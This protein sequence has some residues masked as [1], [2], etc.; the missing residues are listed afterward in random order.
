MTV[1]R[2]KLGKLMRWEQQTDPEFQHSI[3]HGA[4]YP[5]HCSQERTEGYFAVGL[6]VPSAVDAD[7]V[8]TDTPFLKNVMSAVPTDGDL[9]LSRQDLRRRVQLPIN[10]YGLAI[11]AVLE[12]AFGLLHQ[13]AI[14]V[15]L[16]LNYGVQSVLIVSMYVVDQNFIDQYGCDCTAG[17][18]WI[19]VFVFVLMI[20]EE[21]SSTLEAL[22]LL[23]G[24]PSGDPLAIHS[25]K[26][27]SGRATPQRTNSLESIASVS[28]DGWCMC[29]GAEAEANN[30]DWCLCSMSLCSD[31]GR[32]YEMQFSGYRLKWMSCRSKC[33]LALFV[34]LP[35][36]VL[37]V[38]LL[39]VGSSYIMLS[40]S[41]ED[42]IT[43]MVSVNFIV[44]ID[45]M[46]LS[47]VF[48]ARAVRALRCTPH[49]TYEPQS[50]V[51]RLWAH[52]RTDLRTFVD[53][54]FLTIITHII[55]R[56]L[57]NSSGCDNSMWGLMP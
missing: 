8:D 23:C 31:E 54:F 22:E 25:V 2:R 7:E 1:G 21:L 6:H 12:P 50:C 53:P 51:M 3:M 29:H 43:S 32:L 26:E 28:E 14:I 56:Y 48:P 9:P 34:V 47:G 44:A 39:L 11:A 55:F 24:I 10:I 13:S 5:H 19:G 15:L 37:E 40:S 41:D 27:L 38:M 16:F 35:K 45:E 36:F 57:R 46:I 30:D 4:S 17:L 49:V 42:M 52:V 33:L 20:W 18:Q